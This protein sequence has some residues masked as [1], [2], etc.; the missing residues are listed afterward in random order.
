MSIFLPRLDLPSW[1]ALADNGNGTATLSG[2][3]PDDG[4]PNTVLSL[5]W[6]KISGPGGAVF[7]SETAAATTLTLDA[8]GTYVL[9]L[10]ADDGAARTFG[11]VTVT[12]TS[13][14]PSF[15]TWLA[16]YPSLIGPDALATANPDGDALNNLLEYALG[17]DPTSAASAPLPVV[18]T[19]NIAGTDYLML[20]YDKDTSKTDITYQV[21]TTTDPAATWTPVSDVL[22][23]TA[24]SIEHRKASVPI[25]GAKT[26]LQ[27]KITKP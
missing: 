11:E 6:T 4:V 9:R 13:T 16:G 20:S 22:T 10:T 5:Q 18:G 3:A 7:G 1:L 21:Q 24:G 25:S 26:F 15:S 19:E 27:L 2:T 14:G 12:A 17:G 23:G 8:P